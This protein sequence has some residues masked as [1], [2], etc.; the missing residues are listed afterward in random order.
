MKV[1]E[2]HNF[3]KTMLSSLIIQIS[4]LI[5]SFFFSFCM[6]ALGLL[7][8][9]PNVYLIVAGCLLMFITGYWIDQKNTEINIW[10]AGLT[11][12]ENVENVLHL[13][14]D[15][16]NMVNNYTIPHKNCDIDHLLIGPKGIFVIETKN[17]N[18]KVECVGD[19]WTYTKTGKN[20]GVYRGHINNP[21]R[22]LKRNVWEL[23]K[24]LEK[25]LGGKDKFP[26]W[27][28]GILVFTNIHAELEMKDE[29]VV[30]LKTKQLIPFL[31]KYQNEPLEDSKIQSILKIL[32][33]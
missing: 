1:I 10:R 29:T 5:F 12:Q 18:G 17:Y 32:S 26:Y 11:G 20:G 2:K 30:V 25:K 3:V 27:I 6:V 8:E 22:Q 28:Q 24:Y 19:S 16:W 31:Q 9:N 21:S 15:E 4:F 33:R 14:S 13:L 23:R 7:P